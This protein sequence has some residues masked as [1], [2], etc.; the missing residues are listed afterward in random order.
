MPDNIVPQP[1]QK[2][3]FNPDLH[4]MQYALENGTIE[5]T[6]DERLMTFWVTQKH[7]TEMFNLDIRTV[8]QA[9][10]RFKRER[11]E[12]TESAIRSLRIT[13][14][15]GKTYNVEHYNHSV[16]MSIAYRAHATKQAVAFQR[17]AETAFQE[18][19]ERDH[20]RAI[21]KIKHSRD[22][23]ITGYILGGKTPT[24]ATKRV[25]MMDTYRELSSAVI[26]ISSPKLIGQVVNAEYMA[27][28]GK[29]ASDLKIILNTK[30]IR[31]SLTE[32]QIEYLEW[33]DKTLVRVFERRDQMSDAELIA[34]VTKTV[35]PIAEHFK[36]MCDVM[37]IDPVT[38]Q[39]LLGSGKK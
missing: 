8:S 23:N 14:S 30:S 35:T 32:M 25:D 2:P 34:L 7:M 19:M 6:F 13:A 17:Y 27:L 39:K 31:D 11:P 26:R 9:V 12:D 20:A 15:D 4:P 21:K 29:I 37:G 24:H 22:V 36:V 18:K 5:I 28:F 3:L 16:A 33:A 1:S 38:G 10:T